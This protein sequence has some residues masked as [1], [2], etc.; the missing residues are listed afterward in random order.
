MLRDPDV[1]SII[2]LLGDASIL[3]GDLSQKKSYLLSGLCEIIDGET[4]TWELSRRAD[5]KMAAVITDRMSGSGLT[6]SLPKQSPRVTLAPPILSGD[7]AFDQTSEPRLTLTVRQISDDIVSS[8]SIARRK[9]QRPFAPRE[10]K[11]AQIILSEIPWLHESNPS[12]GG[13]RIR[14]KLSPRQRATLVHLMDGASH[15][16][17]AER[18]H[19][20]PH[21]VH[22]YIKGIFKHYKVNSRA[23][24]VRHFT[25]G[26]QQEV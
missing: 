25:L 18:L 20:S 14:R 11:M 17:I 24:L 9:G 10:I 6:L 26:W 15:K 5:K 21:T 4:W 22:G 16:T 8:I 2:R 19:I 12:T 7:L 23:E 3:V 13:Q 1:R